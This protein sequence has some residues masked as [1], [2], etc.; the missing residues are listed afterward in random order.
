M[1]RDEMDAPWLKLDQEENMRL[2][3]LS[4]NLYMLQDDE[5]YEKYEGTQEELRASLKAALDRQDHVA[6]LSLLR[7]GVTSL[8]LGQVASLRGHSYAALG[9]LETAL[10]FLHYAA[11]REP[12]E[13]GHAMFLIELLLRLNRPE[14]ALAETQ[15]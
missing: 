15:R 12:E 8:T 4:A 10:P 3:G 1:V 2:N 5:V 9:H 7:K 11:Q 13:A 6:I 14:D